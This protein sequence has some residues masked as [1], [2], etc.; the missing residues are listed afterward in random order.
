[1][2]WFNIVC[3]ALLLS[4]IANVFLVWYCAKLVR[5]LLGV[6]STL[7]ELFVDI[8]S[9]SK[10]L[11]GV[12]E[13]EMFYGDQTLENLLS[14]ARVLTKE[15]DKY[16]LLFSLREPMEESENDRFIRQEETAAEIEG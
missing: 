8:E 13:L 3:I 11:Q 7:E 16:E 6:S 10:H 9:F 15:F 14:H 2:M 4:A 12:Y 5:E 1:M